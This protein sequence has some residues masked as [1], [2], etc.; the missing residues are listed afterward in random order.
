IQLDSGETV[1]EEDPYT[2]S[3]EVDYKILEQDYQEELTATQALNAELSNAARDLLERLESPDDDA[4]GPDAPTAEFP[5][6]VSEETVPHPA[7]ARALAEADTVEMPAT[8]REDDEDTG[9]NEELKDMPAAQNDATAEME[10]EPAMVGR[11]K[12]NVS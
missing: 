5:T 9:V 11:K 3:R 7:A 8:N 6:L 4:A 1:P 12:V 2:L 10:T